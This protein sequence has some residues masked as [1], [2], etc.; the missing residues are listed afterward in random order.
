M[1]DH[2]GATARQL[3]KWVE[4]GWLDGG[5]VNAGTGH[6]RAWT[7]RDFDTARLMVR[8]MRSGF[9]LER[10]HRLAKAIVGKQ[11][12]DGVRIR[13]EENMWVIVKEI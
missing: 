11:I 12:A 2:T 1:V 8:F 13:I 7:Q 10:A 6:P 5:G 4:K 3:T 9:V